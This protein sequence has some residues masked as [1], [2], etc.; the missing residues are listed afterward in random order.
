MSK[1]GA[2]QV[3]TNI[4]K[5]GI[6]F[7][8][9][10]W[11]T[12]DRSYR[13]S[14]VY[15]LVLHAAV[16]ALL[17]SGWSSQAEVRP[18]VAPRHINAVVVDASVLDAK[19][20]ETDQAKK[21]I[22][23]QRQKDRQAQKELEKKKA[24]EKKKKA[25]QKKKTDA[26]KKKLLEKKKAVD[27]KKKEEAQKKA[28]I[29][30]KEEQKKRA[31]KKQREEKQKQEAE[32]KR[33]KAEK[34]KEEEKRKQALLREQQ[35]AQLQEMMLKAE[36]ERQQEIEE[37]LRQQQQ[38]E[39][40]RLQQAQ[41]KA[42]Q[43]AEMNEVDRFIALIRAKITRNWH[44]PPGAKIGSTVVLQLH[45][46]PTGE[47]GRAEILKSSGDSTFDRS[48]LSAATSISKYPVPADNRVFERNFRRFSM[49]FS[50]QED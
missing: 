9:Q 26:E 23:N 18:V 16:L 8:M 36:Q 25:E 29:K 31:E 19:K 45:L 12:L 38:R 27:K 11:Q 40:D 13:R 7:L 50:H 28:L 17:G 22:E 10:F 41:L 6:R 3:K 5:S 33:I 35:E 39:A 4:L 46:F 34:L 21:R 20:K 48:A 47:L 2:K 32:A 44:K 14:I 30:K 49:S 24:L 43:I 15:A 42:D 1:N 37:R